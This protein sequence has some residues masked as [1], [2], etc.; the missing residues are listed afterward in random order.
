MT[1]ATTKDG[2]EKAIELAIL[3][4]E[5]QYGKGSIMRLGSGESP[6]RAT[7]SPCPRIRA[8]S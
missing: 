5:K 2:R 1:T 6:P 3:Q 8:A 4:I 7:G